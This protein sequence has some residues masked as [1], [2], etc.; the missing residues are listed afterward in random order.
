MNRPKTVFFCADSDTTC[1]IS[2]ETHMKPN[3]E[4]LEPA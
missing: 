1:I 4:R 2:G 3:K